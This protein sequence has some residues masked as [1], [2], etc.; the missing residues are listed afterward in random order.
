MTKNESVTDY[1][2]RAENLITDLRD[3]GGTLSDQLVTPMILHDAD[4]FNPPAVH[5]T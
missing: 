1:E 2:I 4:F 3:G 5:E